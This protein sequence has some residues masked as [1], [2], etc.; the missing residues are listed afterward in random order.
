MG[1]LRYGVMIYQQGKCNTEASKQAL[2]LPVTP[3]PPRRK[4]IAPVWASRLHQ[5][6]NLF[7]ARLY[8][9]IRY[10]SMVPYISSRHPS[11]HA[12]LTHRAFIGYLFRTG[13]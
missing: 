4:Q 11:Y 2:S 1:Q 10:G 13:Q 3:Q 12:S 6:I 5:D 9:Q 7:A 8:P